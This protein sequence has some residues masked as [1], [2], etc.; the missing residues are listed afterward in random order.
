ML[1]RIARFVLEPFAKVLRKFFDPR[2][3]KLES[4][5][6]TTNETLEAVLARDVAMRDAITVTNTR[7]SA[8]EA[9][10][11]DAQ[12]KLDFL[13]DAARSAMPSATEQLGGSAAEL[14]NHAE[15]HRGFRSQAGLWFNPPDVVRYSAGTVE[16]SVMTERS[17]E[18]PFVISNV[19]A[20]KEKGASVLDVGCSESLIPFDLA[21]IG[22]N[23]TGIDLREYPLDHPNL[24]TV[25]TPLE[26]WDTDETFDVVVCLSS[27]EH[28][29]LGTYGEEASSERLDHTAM[30][31]LLKM[32]EPSGLLVM[33]IPFG[34]TDVTPVQRMYD[35][36]DIDELLRGWAIDTFEVAVP[37]AQGWVVSEST[38]EPAPTAD[39]PVTRQVA[40]ITAHPDV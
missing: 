23:V 40:L 10:L 22:Y 16:L 36:A 17:I 26:D 21:S 25:A 20:A 35:R 33:T 4:Q 9:Y 29:G 18:V 5:I 28:F 34:E 37:V 8:A 3:F 11:Q 12:A 14:L 7:I 2:F 27:I 32:I 31:L 19:T 6:A 13:L 1:K 39:P 15:S 30:Q 38:P 24:T